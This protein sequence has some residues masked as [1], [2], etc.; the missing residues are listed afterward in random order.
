MAAHL[1]PM[2]RWKEAQLPAVLGKI[3]TRHRLIQ[4]QTI[5]PVRQTTTTDHQRAPSTQG[6]RP[7]QIRTR[8]RV[9]RLTPHP[10]QLLIQTQRQATT[11]GTSASVA[12]TPMMDCQLALPLEHRARPS[13]QRRLAT[14]SS[15]IV[16]RPDRVLVP[17]SYFMAHF[18]TLFVISASV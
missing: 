13:H 2:S 7:L 14:P 9:L 15:S 4:A 11:P 12:T 5:Q 8:A 17:S 1:R 10:I 18:V 16:T 3:A 6:H